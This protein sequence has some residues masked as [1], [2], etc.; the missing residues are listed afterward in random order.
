MTEFIYKNKKRA[1]LSIKNRKNDYLC[2]L[3]SQY[4]K[5]V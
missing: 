2:S 3:N 4:S 1:N 5:N